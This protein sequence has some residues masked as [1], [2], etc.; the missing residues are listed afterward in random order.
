MKRSKKT[1]RTPFPMA[2]STRISASCISVAL[3]P[4]LLQAAPAFFSSCTTLQTPR[5]REILL[6]GE[7]PAEVIDL[8]FFD[9]LGVQRLDAYQQLTSPPYYGLSGSGAK[10]VVALSARSGSASLW[11]GV[12]TYGNLCKHTFSLERDSPENPLLVGEAL[13]EDG[14]SR[15]LTLPLR[16]MLSAIRLKSLSC[17]FTGRLYAGQP[18][19][20][21]RIYLTYAGAECLPVGPE[22]RTVSLIN[23]GEADGEALKKL[24]HPEM[25]LQEGCGEVGVERIYPERTFYCY[26]SDGVRLVLEGH[27]GDYLC[28]YPIPLPPL[29]ASACL[30]LEITLQRM[31]SPSPDIPVESGTVLV[32]TRTLPWEE[33]VQYTI[34]Y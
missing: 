3:I 10:R 19:D 31:G 2:L 7:A 26:P 24:P 34:P 12:N 29:E 20:N 27:I 13:V 25:I 5:P 32:E 23:L 4:A 9:T 11:L 17:D 18:F 22:S 14:A 1:G 8:F 16:T 21:A 33:R 30:S 15:T 28:Y 6:T